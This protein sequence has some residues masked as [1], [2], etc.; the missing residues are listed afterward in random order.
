MILA[1]G[2]VVDRGVVVVLSSAMVAS[3]RSDL[4]TGKDEVSCGVLSNLLLMR[5]PFVLSGSFVYS[6]PFSDQHHLHFGLC[7]GGLTPDELLGAFRDGGG[8]P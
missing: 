5:H 4:G 1:S 7:C 6:E 2:D 3:E 8:F